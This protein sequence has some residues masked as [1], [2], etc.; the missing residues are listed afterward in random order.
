MIVFPNEGSLEDAQDILE[1]DLNVARVDYNHEKNWPK[2]KIHH[3]DPQIFNSDKNLL[4]N[5]IKDK[6]E[7]LDT[8]DI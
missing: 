6:N 4:I 1:K 7:I 8:D 3:L 5:L 2:L